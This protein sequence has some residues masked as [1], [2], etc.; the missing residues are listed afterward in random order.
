MK[1]FSKDFYVEI[2]AVTKVLDEWNNNKI[3]I[4]S[5]MTACED[6]T[7][8]SESS[9]VYKIKEVSKSDVSR[10]FLRVCVMLLK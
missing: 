6:G 5:E 1:K 3:K 9:K 8:F 2:S 7:A 4:A 10:Y